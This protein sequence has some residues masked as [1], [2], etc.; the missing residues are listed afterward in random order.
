[1][2]K[3]LEILATS[4][5]AIAATVCFVIIFAVISLFELLQLL[6]V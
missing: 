6:F 5:L 4:A 3:I 1:M 2:F